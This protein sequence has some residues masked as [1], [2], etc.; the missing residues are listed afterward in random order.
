M[1][2]NEKEEKISPRGEL[3]DD[4]LRTI[5]TEEEIKRLDRIAIKTYKR[6][7]RRQK[8]RRKK[9]KEIEKRLK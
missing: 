6:E 3:F 5:Y 2:N 9:I 8:K 4:F 1:T 7:M